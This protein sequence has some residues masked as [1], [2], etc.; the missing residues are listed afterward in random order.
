MIDALLAGFL[1]EGLGIHIGTRTERLEPNGARAIAVKVEDAG[2][3]VI[4]YVPTIAA[5]RVLP[6]LEANGQAAVVFGRPTDDRAC[7]VKG[8]FVDSRAATTEER[9]LV[10]AQWNGYLDKL[11]TIGIP[12]AAVAGWINWPA[13]AIRLRVTALFNQTPGPEAGT[14]LQ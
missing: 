8:I 12:R 13:V 6:D 3:Q 4:V 9:F 1:Q 14:R 5:H 2:R 11:G 7:Q 10:L